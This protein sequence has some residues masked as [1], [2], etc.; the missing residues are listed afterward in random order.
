[1]SRALLP[2]WL[3]VISAGCASRIVPSGAA[4]V[5]ALPE[6]TGSEVSACW[7]EYARHGR[8]TASGIVVRQPNHVVIVDVGQSLQFQAQ[9]REVYKGRFYLKKV[10]GALVPDASAERALTS[11]GVDLGQVEAVV[12]TH[13]H[14]DHM[15]GLMDLP[16]LP[17]R[18][19]PAELA[20]LQRVK[21][22][23]DAFNVIPVH[24]RTIVPM[25]QAVSFPYE[26]YAGF[27]QH[28]DLLGNG[29]LVLVPLVGHTAGSI[30]VFIDAGASRILHVGDA[31]NNRAQLERL[32]GKSA[33]LQRADADK[34]VA[35]AQV[36]KLASLSSAHPELVVLPAHERQ[37]WEALFGA[38]GGCLGGAE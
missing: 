4:A 30:G 23:G 17:V 33:L 18:L 3:C 29:T 13:A 36:D 22:G 7:V 35:D 16:E 11:A 8:H 26:P 10:P 19:H 31:I 27:D 15:G 37:A 24:A 2:L 21:D 5:G 1:M 14:S 25:A 28:A 12:L 38:P 32:R 34:D 9:V 20:T 6:T